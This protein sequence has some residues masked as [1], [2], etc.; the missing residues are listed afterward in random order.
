MLVRER[1]AQNRIFDSLMVL[2]LYWTRK[3][4]KWSMELI[5]SNSHIPS[6]RNTSSRQAHLHKVVRWQ[7]LSNSSIPSCRNTSSRQ[8]HLHKVVRWQVLSSSSSLRVVYP[9]FHMAAHIQIYCRA[10]LED[11]IDVTTL[12]R[13]QRAEFFDVIDNLGG[14]LKTICGNV[15]NVSSRKGTQHWNGLEVRN[16]RCFV[17]CQEASVILLNQIG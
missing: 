15:V 4:S 9:H 14:N 3:Q 2:A 13:L 1:A 6:C 8:V 7:V 11:S 10:S 16:C 5:A 17:G 12:Q